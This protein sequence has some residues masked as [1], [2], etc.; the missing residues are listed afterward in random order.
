[1]LC[2]KCHTAIGT[3]GICKNC[4]APAQRL[5]R[6]WSRFAKISIISLIIAAFG[7]YFVLNHFGMVDFNALESM[8]RAPA[9]VAED[10]PPTD[11]GSVNPPDEVEQ[12]TD[13]EDIAP[14]R[15]SE[16]EHLAMLTTAL[17]A[18]EAYVRNHHVSNPL[19]SDMGYLYNVAKGR[20][21]DVA[22]LVSM[23]YL[24]EHFLDEDIFVLYLRPMD[25]MAFEE[26]DMYGI[27]PG[28]RDR[29]AVFV[30]WQTPLGIG[31]YSVH[32]QYLIFRE[33][34]NQLLASYNRNNG[35]IWRPTADDV[36]Y[37]AFV[38]MIDT[39]SDA[40]VFVRHMAVDDVHGFAAF[41]TGDS[42]QLHNYIFALE[43]DE[44]TFSRVSLIARGF[45]ATAHPMV[46]INGAAPNFNFDLLPN[47]DISDTAL[48]AADTRDFDEVLQAAIDHG[49]V[50]EEDEPLFASTTPAFAYM[51]FDHNRVFF[52]QY[53]QG[54]GW[55]IAQIESWRE[56]EEFMAET[57]AHPPLYILWQN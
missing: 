11:I 31:L 37:T 3:G 23:Q 38:D 17:A 42:Q 30:A 6:N 10:P 8:F 47:Y 4:G 52:G 55:S 19:I 26:V 33:H 40:P 21:I 29:M 22:L 36:V 35:E 50:N 34:L 25:L 51:V 27:A 14:E 32:G 48:L 53:A 7:A 44:N 13:N 46:A 5:N 2:V 54:I 43:Y 57:V 56:A 18:A 15:R 20:H 12:P 24:D 16:E 41:T 1:M 28:Q 49:W 39:T 45:E 9:Q